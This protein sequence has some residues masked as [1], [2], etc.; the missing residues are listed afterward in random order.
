LER[1]KKDLYLLIDTKKVGIIL[2]R[3]GPISIKNID[4]KGL[5]GPKGPVG[6]KGLGVKEALVLNLEQMQ[7]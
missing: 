1:L 2:K 4:P 6:P 7:K 5:V 3:V